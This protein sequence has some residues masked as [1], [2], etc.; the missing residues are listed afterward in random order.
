MGRAGTYNVTSLI[1]I[2]KPFLTHNYTKPKALLP[3]DFLA[4]YEDS[5]NT[6][7]NEVRDRALREAMS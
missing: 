3:L 4:D 7:N 6:G 5:K 2:L 1:S